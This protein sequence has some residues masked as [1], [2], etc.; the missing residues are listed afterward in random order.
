M[1]EANAYLVT[2]EK[3]EEIMKNVA[4]LRPEGETV[5]LAT[6]FGERQTIRARIDSIDFLSH[7]VYLTPIPKKPGTASHA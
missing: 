7:K 2:E 5:V 4:I 1:C 3:Q 6:L